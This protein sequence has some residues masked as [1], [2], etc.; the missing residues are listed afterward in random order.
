MSGR[1]KLTLSGA[2]LLFLV[3]L[4]GTARA[5]DII[6][7]K[8][9]FEDPSAG[10]A[11]SEIQKQ[12]F[13]PYER[14]FSKGYSSSNFWFKL[15]IDPSKITQSTNPENGTIILRI[16]PPYLREVEFF[17][18]AYE[19]PNRRLSGDQHSSALDEYHSLNLSFVMPAGETARDVY[20]R[21]NTSS[22]TFI[23]FEAYPK[24]EMISHDY[25]QLGLFALF[26]SFVIVS[27]FYG[28]IF[29]ALSRD[30]IFYF[31]LIRQAC[32]LYWASAA[33]GIARFLIPD[34]RFEHPLYMCGAAITITLSSEFFDFYFFR[35]FRTRKF[36]QI[37]QL[38]LMTLP[39][40]SAVILIMGNLRLAMEVNLSS[41]I[42]F[43]FTSGIG[44]WL[45]YS[46][47]APNND[48]NIV[49]KWLVSGSYTAIMIFLLM[50]LTP[51]L[52]L[53]PNVE[54][55]IYSVAFHTTISTVLLGIIL[56][57]RSIKL[58]SLKAA[59]EI[60]LAIMAERLKLEQLSRQ[61]QAALLAMLSHELKTPLA[62][63]QMSLGAASI[64]GDKRKKISRLIGEMADL[65]DRCLNV[66]NIDDGVIT[67]KIERC[68]VSRMLSTKIENGPE[69]GRF[70]AEIKPGLLIKTDQK[71]LDVILT[72]L[73]DN[74]EKYSEPDHPI[75][76]ESKISKASEKSG[77][78][79]IVS[80]SPRDQIWPDPGML[81]QKYYRSA[82]ALR[83]AGSGLGLY[84]SHKLAERLG[85]ELSYA[86]DDHH[87]RFR[88]W[89][90]A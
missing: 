39:L 43:T 53:F 88:L 18:P 85:G 80:N 36:I 40:I 63:I 1:I 13:K 3:A 27:V 61:D 55:A 77:I 83:Q 79:I 30:R 12:N 47:K 25:L 7:S 24:G 38:V 70:T 82:S 37:F 76:I 65:I 89:L 51:Q 49:P 52:G 16:R 28:F 23:D 32:S 78:E 72:N 87:V 74:A 67:L 22:S 20:V 81:F 26:I 45:I 59:A 41:A 35:E 42:I 86:P 9:Y 62:G 71:L 90:P 2:V 66:G 5:D 14:P 4:F 11:F 34:S 75:L 50:T 68:D 69:P 58:R 6:V 57:Y 8:A 84:I 56:T 48:P 73:I 15:T 54:F 60:E 44:S 19:S 46:E 17:D 29:L 64:Q 31:F 10:L 21:L 33:F